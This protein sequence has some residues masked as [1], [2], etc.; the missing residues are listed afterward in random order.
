[1][2]PGRIFYVYQNDPRGKYNFRRI[3]RTELGSSAPNCSYLEILL[4]C[5]KSSRI[6]DITCPNSFT[7]ISTLE[8]NQHLKSK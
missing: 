6:L 5:A 3:T 1:M 8:A 7:C 4:P 2:A